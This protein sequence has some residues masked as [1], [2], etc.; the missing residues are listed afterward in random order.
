M[1]RLKFQVHNTIN[2]KANNIPDLFINI[3]SILCIF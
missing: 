2:E 3:I 1:N